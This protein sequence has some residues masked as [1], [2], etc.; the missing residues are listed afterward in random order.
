M[1]SISLV[2][3]LFIPFCGSWKNTI[4][5]IALFNVRTTDP[6]KSVQLRSFLS[7]NLK[8]IGIILYFLTFY[9]SSYRLAVRTWVTWRRWSNAMFTS[10]NNMRVCVEP[11]LHWVN[12]VHR[13]FLL[14]GYLC[15]GRK[16]LHCLHFTFTLQIFPQVMLLY[17]NNVNKIKLNVKSAK[18]WHGAYIKY[19][20]IKN[21]HSLHSYLSARPLK[22]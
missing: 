9:I 15:S 20:L 18:Y 10:R 5:W 17:I 22:F 14:L 4:R 19:W 12:L 3:L 11:S 7:I 6:R 21:V 13:I 1:S 16:L 8:S 2:S